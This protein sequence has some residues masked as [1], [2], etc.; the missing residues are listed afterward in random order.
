VTARLV[1]DDAPG[2]AAADDALRGGGIVGLPT[3]TVYGIAVALDTPGGI[4]RLFAL[5]DRPP[6][7]AIMVLADSLDQVAASV[8]IP[9]EA[10]VLA[11]ACWPG[12]LTLVLP[13][14]VGAV[15]PPALSAGT[16][17]LGVRIPDHPVPRRIAREIGPIPTTSANRHGEPPALDGASVLATLG[18]RLDVVVDAGRA[19]GGTSSTVIDCSGGPP[20]LLRAGAIPVDALAAVLD[21]AEL[22]HRL[23]TI[24]DD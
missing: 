1:S 13:L 9:A 15:V 18:D 23:G 21:E 19:R 16:A 24:D 6:D 14:R 8:E 3:D 2:L 4:E 11:A 5:K 17:T 7:R 12:G 22:P 10:R 20:R